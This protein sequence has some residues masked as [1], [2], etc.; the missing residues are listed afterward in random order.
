MKNEAIKR[1]K[2]FA[3]YEVPTDAE[4]DFDMTTIN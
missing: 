3:D 4:L 2:P 1:G